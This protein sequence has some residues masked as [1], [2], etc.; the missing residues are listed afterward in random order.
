MEDTLRVLPNGA[1]N[2]IDKGLNPY[3]NGRYSTREAEDLW[4]ELIEK[5]LILIIMEDTLRVNLCLL[6]R[7]QV[8]VLILIIM[9]DTLRELQNRFILKSVL[10]LNPYYN[11]RYSTR[12][13]F[14]IPLYSST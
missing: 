13:K 2:D 3:Y 11:G 5:V 14:I 6:L 7:F 8:N 10:S 1:D 9:E 4:N 12:A